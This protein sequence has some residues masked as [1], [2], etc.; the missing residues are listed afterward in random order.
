[1]YFFILI[2]IISCYH[3]FGGWMQLRKSS[4]ACIEEET[5]N[6]MSPYLYCVH[7]KRLFKFFVRILNKKSRYRL[8]GFL[9]F[10][11][12][13]PQRGQ[14]FWQSFWPL[15]MPERSGSLWLSFAPGFT[16]GQRA[17]GSEYVLV[18][19]HHRQFLHNVSIDCF[20][21]WN[22]SDAFTAFLWKFWRYLHQFC[23]NVQ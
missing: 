22:C 11:T 6:V 14:E 20:H 21:W 8:P 1:M 12:R 3:V 4:M 18:F 9:N 15:S 19:A 17:F 10:V 7:N 2:I 16:A 13:F 23:I 5:V